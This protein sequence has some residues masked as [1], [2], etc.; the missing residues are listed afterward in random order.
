MYAGVR[1]LF[2]R[3]KK[4]YRFQFSDRAD[5]CVNMFLLKKKKE[6]S[7]VFVSS[8]PEE[9]KEPEINCV[10]PQKTL[11][12]KE[13]FMRSM[14]E[15]CKSRTSAETPTL[16][17]RYTYFLDASS[18]K[19]MSI[20]FHSD[21]FKPIILVQVFGRSHIVL[22][23]NDWMSIPVN[24][25]IADIYFSGGTDQPTFV[26]SKNIVVKSLLHGRRKER[27]ILLKRTSDNCSSQEVILNKT[28]WTTLMRLSNFFNTLAFYL[29]KGTDSIE[30]YYNNYVQFCV[31]KKTN[32]LTS[33]DFF[34]PIID[35]DNTY[36]YSRLF[37]EIPLLCRERLHRD[38]NA[39]HLNINDSR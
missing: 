27:Y 29:R 33:K 1:I 22:S 13:D 7:K 26:C 31:S 5:A 23:L 8:T 21:T 37:H 2:K 20:G 24:R 14:S 19:A 36:N 12:V 32:W 28:E 17:L 16:L 11:L 3:L 38:I 35:T 39:F 10:Q 4:R 18:K 15:I 30:E 6:K 9:R 25:D 34:I